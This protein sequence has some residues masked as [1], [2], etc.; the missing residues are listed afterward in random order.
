MEGRFRIKRENFFTVLILWIWIQPILLQYI[1]AFMMRLPLIGGYSDIIL[2]V[3]FSLLI[4]FSIPYYRVTTHDCLFLITVVAIFLFQWLFNRDTEQYLSKYMVS[5]LLNRLPLFV[6]GVSLG[7]HEKRERIIHLMYILALI[8]LASAI[9][10]R[11]AFGAP[12]SDAVSK[13]KGDMDHAYK[14]LPYCCLIA[15]YGIQKPNC[16]NIASIVLGG[17]YLLML[18]TR[19][20]AMLYLALI[21]VLLIKGKK[22]KRITV[23]LILGIGAIAAFVMSPLYNASI[24]CMY[25]IAQQFGLSI[26]VF[27]KLLS[28]ALNSSSGRDTIREALWGAIVNGP[29]LGYGICGDRVILNGGFAH[30]IAFELWTDFGLFLGSVGLIVMLLMIFQGYRGAQGEGL[31]GL[32]LSLIFASFLMMFLSGSIL[33]ERFPMFLLGLCV[34]SIRVCNASKARELYHNT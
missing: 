32:I 26:R 31:K 12:M 23:R 34:S 33:D 18:G 11:F 9:L 5:F 13:Y 14:I 27:D 19:G 6:V 24:L 29:M 25:R 16:I 3:C 15:Y 8:S 2:T 10:Y 28:G 30:N 17:L 4:L 7:R 21:A 20:A 22:S 1:R